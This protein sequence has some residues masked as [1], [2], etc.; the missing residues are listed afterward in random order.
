MF[1]KR[2]NWNFNK[3]RIYSNIFT[4][5]L[6]ILYEPTV[7][8]KSSF[9]NLSFTDFYYLEWHFNFDFWIY[10]IRNNFSESALISF[11]TSFVF[12]FFCRLFDFLYK[13]CH[14]YKKLKWSFKSNALTNIHKL[15]CWFFKNPY[16]ILIFSLLKKDASCVQ[17]GPQ[18]NKN[19]FSRYLLILLFR[20]CHDERWLIIENWYKLVIM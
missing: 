15:S 1:G 12:I 6:L 10:F 8:I 18:L 14:L 11:R 16:R 20:A 2:G 4:Q 7:L 3:L 5:I 17:G 13:N 19:L 9:F